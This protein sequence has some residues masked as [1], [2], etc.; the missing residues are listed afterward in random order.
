M[1]SNLDDVV[2]NRAVSNRN[3]RSSGDS[4]RSRKKQ[5]E[6]EPTGTKS[7]QLM[8]TAILLFLFAAL[9]LLALISYSSLD[10]ANAELSLRDIIGV[11]RGDDAMLAR[12]DTTR[13]WL[14]LL[15]AVI[16][17]Y[18]Y[19][20]SVGYAAISF[21]F[22]IGFWAK[23][24]YQQGRISRVVLERSGLIFVCCICIASFFGTLQHIEW[25]PT[26]AREWSGSVGAMLSSF[27]CNFLGTIGS[28][29][30]TTVAT[31]IAVAITIDLDIDHTFNRARLYYARLADWVTLTYQKI[32]NYDRE[33]HTE[34]PVTDVKPKRS[35]RS[36]RPTVEQDEETVQEEEDINEQEQDDDSSDEQR[37]AKIIRLD[38]DVVDTRTGE[39]LSQQPPSGVRRVAQS[40]QPQSAFP[41]VKRNHI[42]PI[43]DAEE[44]E[45]EIYDDTD[46]V[47]Q[48]ADE[49]TDE[50]NGHTLN[51]KVEEIHQEEELDAVDQTNIYDEEIN[52]VP[53]G[54]S[55]LH[56]QPEDIAVNDAELQMNARILQE[57]LET[58]KIK[59]EDVTVTPGPVITQY[60]FVPA[61]GVK[62]SQIESLTDDIA[63]A[64]K[65][66]GI[67]IIAPVPGKG[68]VGVEIPNHKPATVHFSSIIKS[69]AFNDNDKVLP[70]AL[71]KTIIGEVFCA[72]LAKMPHLL[73]AGS[74]GSGKSVGINT[75]IS[76]L[77]YKMHPRDLKFVIIDPKK[78]EM[79]LYTK[80]K[81]HFF[82][83]SPDI[84]E[85]VVTTPQNAVAV[86]KSLC[87]EM[88]QRYDLLSKVGQ[89]NIKDY[90][91]KVLEGKLVERDGLK[92]RPLP[93]IVTVIDELADLM[94]TARNEVEEPIIRIAQLARAVGIHMI[95]ATQ[96]PSV[97]VITGLIKANFPAR[98]AYQVA[99]KIDS[100]TVLDS[101]GA[102]QLLGNGDML[103]TPGGAKPMRLQNS[104]IST[105]EVEAIT[106]FIGKQ[107]GYSSAYILPSI[108]TKENGK[109]AIAG[110]FDP[111]F[112]DAARTIVQFQQGS[113]SLLQRRLKIGYSRAARIVDELESAGIVGAFDGSKARAV[114]MESEAEL[115]MRLTELGLE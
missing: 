58:F 29:L 107:R 65:A 49:T 41:Q 60:E 102:E 98:I 69:K 81:H 108:L 14:G 52:Y 91:Q 21:P 97:D 15:G 88:E 8:I 13:N 1:A 37:T 48:E 11:L 30:V 110:D 84:D 93:Y 17:N 4:Q 18:F 39:I 35:R 56:D 57:K 43:D 77:V 115:D 70:I 54:M 94:I 113:V 32:R 83:S 68:T 44:V 72:D 63:L 92:L 95:I 78:V 47:S 111:L 105:D 106:D 31:F 28:L 99:S 27:L 38:T 5:H 53:P 96:R 33:Q 109:S 40:A 36:L 74:T 10:E 3:R 62:I 50:T 9:L 34:Q 46:D 55:L 42:Q 79:S 75:I 61:A 66:R 114:L 86:L 6:E 80:L 101:Q 64:L 25:L 16:A 90:N 104:F 45:E 87:L 51:L 23:S 7:R 12:V 112:S 103:F 82:A 59:I 73:I 67:R 26:L 24:L 85:Y 100:R 2:I 19:N 22:I 89:R 71:G 20:Y 76:S